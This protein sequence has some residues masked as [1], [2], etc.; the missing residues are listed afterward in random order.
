VKDL[1]AKQEQPEDII[2]FWCTVD[3]LQKLMVLA[4]AMP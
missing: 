2:N 4:Y 1:S 3:R